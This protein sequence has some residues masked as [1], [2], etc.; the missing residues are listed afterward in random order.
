MD[1]WQEHYKRQNMNKCELEHHQI[2]QNTFEYELDLLS[3]CPINVVARGLHGED[4]FEH[5]QH[6]SWNGMHRIIH[7]VAAVFKIAQCNSGTEILV[8]KQTKFMSYEERLM[9]LCDSNRRVELSII[10]K[11][12]TQDLP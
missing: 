4:Y 10:I 6:L 7:V 5:C 3:Q 11:H 2:T 12:V 9:N 8:Y 1:V